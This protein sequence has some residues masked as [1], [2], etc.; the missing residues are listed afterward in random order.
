VVSDQIVLPYLWRRYLSFLRALVGAACLWV[1]LASTAV[2]T[3]TW[4]ILVVTLT[5]YSLVSIFWRWPER[6]DKLDIFNLVLD[7]VTF[8]LCVAL[9]DT[10]SLWLAAVAALYLFLAM[11]TL[12]D[13][14]DVL[15]T[16]VLSLAF[17]ISARPPNADILEPLVLILG[18]FGCV[19][20]LQKQS[21]ID[22]LS[23]TSRQAVLYRK[24]AQQAREA[25]RER[26]AAD[27]HDGPLQSFISIQMRLE[28]VRKMLERNFDAGMA[29][30]KELREICG[31]QVTEVRTFVR[32]M[33]PVEVDGAG[34]AAALRSTV[35]FFQKDSG[36]P[37]TFKVD[38][39]AM[40]DDIDSSTE[41]VQIVREALNNVRK[42]SGASRV[43]VGLARAEDTL[44]IDVEDDG[45]GFPFAGTFSLE[46]LELLRI[47][48]LSIQRRVRGLSGD[49]AL[50]SR[51]GRGSELKIR[52]PI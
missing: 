5:I 7:V 22:R 13:W 10:D 11:A 26:I 25:E 27:F 6:I 28:I 51:P 21:L 49:L 50:S 43:A 14:R 44:L 23:N 31:Q 41:V 37:A 39:G 12:Q 17:I 34:L 18:M 47:G 40:H 3:G 29:E 15:L 48:P 46:E 20:A 2:A 19:V 33:R 32:S 38:P 16:T 1:V 42:H 30:L 52:L 36:I 45:T 35:G 8:L 9:S 4:L 24:E